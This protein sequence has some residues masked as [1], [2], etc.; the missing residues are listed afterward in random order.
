MLSKFKYASGALLIAL[1]V[2]GCQEKAADSSGSHQGERKVEVG[3]MTIEPQKVELNTELPGR[4]SS[5]L[6]AEIRPQVGGIIEKRLFKAGEDVKA[7]QVLYQLDDSTYLSS[8]RQAQANLESA[9]AGLKSAE[10]KDRRY[11]VLRKQNNV[12]QQDL[13]DAHVAYLEAKATQ[14]GAEAALQNAEINLSH[15]KITSPISGRI[16][17]SQ[18]TVG[19]LVTANQSGVMATVRSLN[20]VYVDLAQTSLE[21]LKLRNLLAQPGLEKGSNKVTLVLEDGS[22][23]DHEGV[24]ES[25]EIDVDESTGSVTLRAVFPN[26]DNVLLP[27]MFVRGTIHQATINSAIVVPQQAVFHDVKGN[28]YCYVVDANNTIEKRDVT[29][30]QTIGSDEW[31]VTKG[32]KAGDRV[33]MEG[34]SKVHPGSQVATVNVKFDSNT[35]TVSSAGTAANSSS[36]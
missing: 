30:Q 3:V 17:I 16:G 24:L 25:S 28:A 27:G 23:Y 20:P 11:T 5:S 8:V 22:K 12:S 29:T 32:I 26:P 31:L 13:D 1:L 9:N 35:D 6:V 33:V 10:L 4:T 34:S 36:N 21:Q 2:A 18:V 15:T 7:G 14:K 19:A